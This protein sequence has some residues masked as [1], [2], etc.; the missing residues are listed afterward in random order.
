MCVC[1]GGARTL[2]RVKAVNLFKAEQFWSQSAQA[3]SLFC[4]FYDCFCRDS[5]PR[6]AGEGIIQMST[7]NI[8]VI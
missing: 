7:S 6:P 1:G 8:T 4:K 3:L 2:F 5:A